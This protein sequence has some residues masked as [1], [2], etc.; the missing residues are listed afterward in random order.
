MTN[1]TPRGAAL[2]IV[3][4]LVSM[5][6]ML[7]LAFF[8]ISRLE[9]RASRAY[10][11]TV[12]T[13]VL[14]D[15]AL[16]AVIAQL[17][18]A[19]S[20]LGT[21]QTWASQPGMIRRYD[22]SGD[23]VGAYKLYSSDTMV[24]GGGFDPE[25]EVPPGDWAD[26]PGQW[27]DLNEPVG[28]DQD[29]D[30]NFDRLVYPIVDPESIGA[31][32][33][34]EVDNAPGAS[35]EQPVPM[36]VKWLYALQDGTLVA[37]SS[38]SGD[39]V[40]ISEASA[41]N[42]IVGRVAFWADDECAK[43]NINTAS[44]GT[45]WDLPRTNSTFENNY[46]N[47]QPVKGEFQ[48]Y[49]G[50][51]AMT[52]LGPILGN[53]LGDPDTARTSRQR[54]SII[55]KYNKLTPRIQS[56]GSNSGSREVTQNTPP[57]DLSRDR[58]RL[59]ASVDEYVFDAS[60]LSGDIRD[61][62]SGMDISGTDSVRD[63]VAKTRF[64]LTAHSQ[65]PEVN[66]FNQPRLCLWP[67][68]ADKGDRNT[69]D[70]LIAF[71]ASTGSG[72][73][74]IPYYLQRATSHKLSSATGYSSSQSTTQDWNIG[75]NKEIYDYLQNLMGRNI[76][77]Y[78]GNFKSKLGQDADQVITEMVDFLRSGLNT[79]ALSRD[80][81]SSYAYAPP[82]QMSGSRGSRGE[83]Q[84]IPLHIGDTKGFGRSVTVTEAALVIYPADDT[85]RWN[86]AQWTARSY[87]E[88]TP[89]G[90]KKAFHCETVRAFLLLEFFCPSVGLPTWS[91]YID[92]EIE[93]LDEF[94]IN[95]ESL[96]MPATATVSSYTPINL[97]PG[98]SHPIGGGNIT[99]HFGI[100]QPLY[101][102]DYTT[103]RGT[104]RS[105]RR[106]G[107]EQGYDFHSK[108]PV[109]IPGAIPGK[110]TPGAPISI[111]GAS[112]TIKLKSGATGDLYQTIEMEFPSTQA[113]R[114]YIY[115]N[116][117]N[118]SS[119]EALETQL[120]ERL[121]QGASNYHWALIRPGDVVR[122]MEPDLNAPPKGD[123]RFHA[124]VQTVPKTWFA[125]GGMT[126]RRRSQSPRIRVNQYEDTDPITGRF[127][128]GLR[129]SN[130]WQFNGQFHA[131]H[132]REN[133]LDAIQGNHPKHPYFRIAS[134]RTAGALVKGHHLYTE[135][136]DTARTPAVYRDAHFVTA[137]DLEGAKRS[138][139][140]PGDFDSG[141]G[142]IEDGPYINK[143]DE[144]NSYGRPFSFK[145]SNANR[146]GGYHNRGH[147]D[148]DERGVNHVPNRQIASAIQMGSLPTG[149]KRNQPWQTLLFNPHPSGE[150]HP[151]AKPPHDHLL[152]DWWWMP[153][154]QPY[155]I[156][157]P[158]AT[159][160]K[161]NLNYDI[162]P[163]RYI[164]RRTPIYSLLESVRLG[165][166]PKEAASRRIM[167]TNYRQGLDAPLPFETRFKIEY[168]DLQQGT[169]KGFEDKFADG[170]IFRSASEIC[171][172]S[173]VPRAIPGSRYW[174]GMER[175]GN[176][177]G[178]QRWW[179][180]YA[181]LTGDNMRETPYNHIY[182]R[183]TTKSN[184]FRVHL[185]VQ[186]IASAGNDPSTIKLSSSTVSGDW[187]GSALLE[188]FVD[189]NDPDLPDFV[190]DKDASI[191]DY[192]R[193]RIIE[194]KEFRPL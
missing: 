13:N 38:T 173:L 8:S 160:G 148:P 105:T 194:R 1:S 187:R 67:I 165:A 156:S 7:I 21:T 9:R 135:G 101:T 68:Q 183:C 98:G 147:F 158:M 5:L 175:R 177:D 153:V 11:Q 179:T 168:E 162:L 45:F 46:A 58:D 167:T 99:S 185:R 141:F 42:P 90:N 31:V 137:R 120:D 94:G 89:G 181:S 62:N 75:R 40:K 163:F 44:V 125:P 150:D 127:A 103:R 113:P 60:E 54:E 56:G 110:D 117:G 112:I 192:Y 151:G 12:E 174:Q 91:P 116:G 118:G 19:T 49:T 97:G 2:V 106:S 170:K 152:L 132:Q 76:P 182:P 66:L 121:K 88:R 107:K 145:G 84:V 16:N 166:I 188:R 180:Q 52:S 15:S 70:E 47:S 102:G 164:K 119:A 33:G 140:K 82:R 55:A 79:Y 114:P 65:A 109:K 104:P 6:M 124:A 92:I 74:R 14:S 71:C 126:T 146:I 131:M 51:P 43:I 133:G 17:R 161:V 143:P 3:I 29:A 30:G 100:F 176:Y 10:A 23:L 87:Q 129:Q 115:S 108:A 77:G 22:D 85:R 41:L 157:Q 159:S 128:H 144:G 178:M 72:R 122:S 189:P 25:S 34:F 35:D 111:D 28:V 96:G 190:S 37:P 78:G 73:N 61:K 27:V 32:K 50:H 130:D 69:I 4:L 139:G 184:T 134:M 86:A 20:G 136:S 169:L 39:E 149:I 171:E 172:I 191:D 63:V 48:R 83:A 142:H 18:Q 93:G 154:S 53:W 138:D 193:I 26:D 59:Y 123:L 57:I 80:R 36:P 81:S 64:F 186:R 24:E 155:P 95:G